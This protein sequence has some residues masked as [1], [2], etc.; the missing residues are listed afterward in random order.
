MKAGQLFDVRGLAVVVTGAAS[1]IGL[2]CAEVM[3]ANGA[4]VTLLDRNA[5]MLE[6]AVG[7]L[8]CDGCE[9]RGDVVD[10]TDRVAVDV[11]VGAAAQ[12]HGG[13]DVVFANAGIGGGSGFL[14]L[15]GQRRPEGAFERIEDARWDAMVE[16]NLSSVLWTIQAAVRRMKERGGGR[17]VVTTSIAAL[18]T[19]SVVGTPYMPVKAAAAMLVRQA[20]LELARYGI[21]V[22]GVAPGPFATDIS[23]RKMH[24]PAVQAYQRRVVPLG[25]IAQ[26]QEIQGLALFLASPASRYVT[27]TQIVIDGGATLGYADEAASRST[28]HE[29]RRHG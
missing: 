19:E 2:A 4:R 6:A 9:V 5:P 15:D 1:G 27:G 23:D 17:I 26:P 21:L 16:G 24:D 29:E 10:V 11:A 7:R 20:A 28:T 18:K 8:R 12:V 3:A 22:N 25:R 13:P 14:A